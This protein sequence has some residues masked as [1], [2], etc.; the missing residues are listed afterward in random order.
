[1]TTNLSM[2][3]FYRGH[4]LQMGLRG[5]SHGSTKQIQDDGR[6]PSWISY[7]ANISAGN[8]GICT[9]LVERCITAMWKDTS[10][11]KNRNMKLI[12]VTSSNERREEKG[13]ELRDCKKYLNQIWYTAKEPENHHAGMCQ[14]HNLK[15]MAAA[16]IL[17]FGKCQY[18]WIGRRYVY[19]MWWDDDTWPR[20]D[21]HMT[22][23]RNRKLIR[24]TSL[25][26]RS[27]QRDIDLRS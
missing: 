10:G 20:R 26:K 2:T 18:L 11:T 4:A 19:Q 25:N 1:M 14:I 7:S 23:S 6:R 27:E 21:D 22:K 16:T 5:W 9:N 17:H 8:K 13:F 15:K 24:V 12:G 3:K